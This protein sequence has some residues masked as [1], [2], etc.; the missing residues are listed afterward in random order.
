[1]K[2]KFIEKRFTLT[3]NLTAT[4]EKKLER[5]EKFFDD[6]TEITISLSSE[7]NSEKTAD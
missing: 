7:G 6:N 4:I 2:K 1:M 5:L 3:P